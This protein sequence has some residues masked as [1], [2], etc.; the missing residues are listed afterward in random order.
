[1][2][3]IFK[4]VSFSYGK[5]QVLKNIS[6]ELQVG[7]RACL[8]GGS[9]AGKTT[10]LRLLAALEKPDSGNISGIPKNGIS[11]VFQENR[12]LPNLSVID[13]L[14]FVS[15][16][17][18]RK[19]FEGYLNEVGLDGVADMLPGELSGGMA[20]RVAIVRAVAF[21]S[22]LLLLDEPFSGLDV[23]TRRKT[24]G[25]ILKYSGEKTIFAVT[26]DPFEAELLKAKIVNI[27][28]LDIF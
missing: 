27:E 7:E 15:P 21:S 6:F 22:E 1:M 9:G 2:S 3:I 26:H 13:N 10:I 11:F 5:K 19:T 28:N 17:I 18:Q 23:E 25:F 14:L 4:N 20:R 16:D 24:A 12:L 8:M